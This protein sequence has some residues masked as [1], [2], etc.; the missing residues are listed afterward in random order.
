LSRKEKNM[1]W[2][3][4]YLIKSAAEALPPMKWGDR[5]T[6][7]AWGAKHPALQ[8]AY[9]GALPGLAIGSMAG[10]LKGAVRERQRGEEEKGRLRMIL[11]DMLGGGISGSALGAAGGLG[12]AVLGGSAPL[13]H[14]Y[15]EMLA[16]QAPPIP[17]PPGAVPP[18]PTP[19]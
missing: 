15:R 1:S 7:P 4:T 13:A 8:T 18:A 19:A 16:K 14:E 5:L 6:F 2:Y 3:E 9:H 11:E 10:G 17:P 12:S